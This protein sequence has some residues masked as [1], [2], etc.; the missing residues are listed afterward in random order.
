MAGYDTTTPEGIAAFRTAI[1]NYPQDTKR[2]MLLNYRIEEGT[3]DYA[4]KI[5]L[6]KRQQEPLVAFLNKH[7]EFLPD[8]PGVGNICLS[9]EGFPSMYE[10]LLNH[11][12]VLVS[13]WSIEDFRMMRTHI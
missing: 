9:I 7:G 5:A 4:D 3:P 10:D 8:K 11:P 2:K 6:W 12:E 1:A 13:I